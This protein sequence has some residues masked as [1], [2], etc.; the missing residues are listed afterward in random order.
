MCAVETGNP[1]KRISTYPAAPTILAPSPLWLGHLFSLHTSHFAWS[2][3]MNVTNS[4]KEKRK[5]CYKKFKKHYSY[6]AVNM[7][8]NNACLMC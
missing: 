4:E 1:P 8:S 5:S 2:G 3:E 7:E 6:D